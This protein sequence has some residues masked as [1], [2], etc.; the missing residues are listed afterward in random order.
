[1]PAQLRAVQVIQSADNQ[2][3][4]SLEDMS[5]AE[6]QSFI[7]G[8]QQALADK[9]EQDARTIDVTPGSAQD[10]AQ[11]EDEDSLTS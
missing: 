10:S 2:G 4:K 7:T 5:I 8:G 9:R 3:E 11:Y 6:L 1:M